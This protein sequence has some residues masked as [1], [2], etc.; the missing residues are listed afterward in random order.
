MLPWLF[1]VLFLL[2]AALFYWSYALERSREPVP[3]ALSSSAYR[4][5]LFSETDGSLGMQ[6]VGST[7]EE[8]AAALSSRGGMQDD[9]LDDGV[10]PGTALNEP[11]ISESQPMVSEGRSD[12]SKNLVNDTEEPSEWTNLV[13]NFEAS[14]NSAMD[15]L[16][17]ESSQSEPSPL[18]IDSGMLQKSDNL[19]QSRE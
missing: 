14:A 8:A 10:T 13:K 18:D 5:Q 11:E 1:A 12:V 7:A 19:Q 2:N 6:Q 3:P 15:L 9:G 17:D 4:I 16:D